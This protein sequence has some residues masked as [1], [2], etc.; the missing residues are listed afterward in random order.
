MIVYFIIK[1]ILCGKFSLWIICTW[2]ELKK[3]L[4]ISLPNSQA[5]ILANSTLLLEKE[6]A[7]KEDIDICGF[8]NDL[9]RE[10]FSHFVF[11]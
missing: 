7:E 5:I 8:V 9:S 1:N 6:V 2:K 4:N 3:I 10:I 11:V